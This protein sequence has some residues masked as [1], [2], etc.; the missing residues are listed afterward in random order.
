MM[1]HHFTWKIHACFKQNACFPVNTKNIKNTPSQLPL[2]C[3][4]D[5]RF[6]LSLTDKNGLRNWRFMWK[7]WPSSLLAFIFKG[8]KRDVLVG[9]WGGGVWEDKTKYGAW[10]YGSAVFFLFLI[11][12]IGAIQVANFSVFFWFDS[13]QMWFKVW[14]CMSCFL[15]FFQFLFY[16]LMVLS[17][18]MWTSDIAF[19]HLR[20]GNRVTWINQQRGWHVWAI[21]N[22]LS[23]GHPKWW[24]SKGIPPKMALN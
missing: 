5:F 6:R 12:I 3:V 8:S 18:E 21:Y 7:P 9:F 20:A 13:T 17:Q 1:K 15:W 24:F 19:D 14:F 2:P 22:D 23:R 11:E 4:Q 16:A 10:I